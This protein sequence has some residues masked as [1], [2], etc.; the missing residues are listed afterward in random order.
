M[1]RS[2]SLV[3][4]VC[5]VFS[6]F[7]GVLIPGAG[8]VTYADVAKDFWAYDEIYYLTDKG[9]LEG[10]GTGNFRPTDEVTHIEFIKMIVA[11]F[12]LVDTAT[13]NYTN[14]P[15]WAKQGRY[16]EKAAAQGFLLDE[17]TKDFDFTKGLTREE[18]VA[19][20]MRYLDL[21]DEIAVSSSR[22]PDYSDI[23]SEYRSYALIAT[24]AGIVQGDDTG[25]FQPDRVLTRSEALRILYTAAGAIY[26]RSASK[27]ETGANKTNATINKSV[28][29]SGITFTGNVY[30]TE[31]VDTV[32]FTD[33]Y[34][35]GNLIVRGNTEVTLYDSVVSNMTVNGSRSEI[36]LEGET[37]IA[38]A[39]INAPVAITVS[40]D[41]L[42]KKLLF[43]DGSKSSSVSG[44]GAVTNIAVQD[45][46]ITTEGVDITEYYIYKGYTATFDGIEY[47][48]GSGKPLKSNITNATVSGSTNYYTSN[49]S[50]I[51]INV[52]TNA[53]GTVY[54]AAWPVTTSALSA[55]DIKTVGSSYNSSYYGTSKSVSANVPTTISMTVA[56][57]YESYNVGIVFLPDGV[58][59]TANLQPYY[60]KST[61]SAYAAAMG[62]DAPSASTSTT[63]TWTLSNSAIGVTGSGN[64]LILTFN[65]I[66]YYKS[67]TYPYGLSSL[68]SLTSSQLANLF[69]IYQ[70]STRITSFTASVSNSLTNTVIYLSP[71]G[72][73]TYGKSYTVAFSSALVNANGIAPATTSSSII[74]GATT[75][76]SAPT[77]T[78]SS[79][80]S[81]VDSNDYIQ[82]GFPTGVTKV[83]YT[84]TVDGVLKDSGTFSNSYASTYARIYLN[85]L[86]GSVITVSA[87]AIDNSGTQISEATTKTYYMGV[88]PT[89]YVDGNAYYGSNNVVYTTNSFYVSAGSVPSGY[90]ASYTV[91]GMPASS[92]AGSYSAPT[93]YSGVTFTMTLRPNNSFVG[94]TNV[95]T[96]V[97][98]MYGTGTGTG[99][100]S[101][102]ITPS[103]SAPTVSV[104]NNTVASGWTYDLSG[105]SATLSVTIPSATGYVYSY[106]VNGSSS[107]L[108]QNGKVSTVTLTTTPYVGVASDSQVLTITATYNNTVVGTWSYSFVFRG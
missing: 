87:W 29:L 104:N 63:P 90:T 70:G 17:Y 106:S 16:L 44:E 12:N 21:D 31:G 10:D 37:E 43:N 20:I 36:E 38:T 53:R 86:S 46:G 61:I 83:A 62:T 74:A 23:S 45:D 8:A 91:N 101:G 13:V 93:Y 64:S 19:L 27:A 102:I 65:Q 96:S 92:I 76:A 51:N 103:A 32:Y 14:V 47:E 48:A 78:S 7:A 95:T 24:G 58:T 49:T 4:A 71:T 94:T 69:T 52:T 50:T 89:I 1:K 15:D 80:S 67:S 60:N 30:I 42:I 77:L 98:V 75:T 22:Y 11:T 57:S 2:M 40:E 55:S 97:T 54:A 35:S 28:N 84:V 73:V 66:M 41:S 56:G 6:L 100:G 33:C 5:L 108:L 72:G 59:T 25:K 107:T 105:T 3:L 82:V 18:A 34:I 79:G 9:I 81:D 99:G 39:E 68:S 88:I 85:R 26:D